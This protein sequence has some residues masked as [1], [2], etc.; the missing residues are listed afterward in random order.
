MAAFEV[1]RQQTL[2]DVVVGRGGGVVG[3]AVG[4]GDR[5]VEC[6]VGHGEP[7]GAGVVEFGEGVLFQLGLEAGFG[8]GAFW[9]T[10]LGDGG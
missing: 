6:F 2:E 3:P 10:G 8:D 5:Y 7:G 1:Q 9:V 4:C